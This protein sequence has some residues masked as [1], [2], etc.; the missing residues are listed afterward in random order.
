M[1]GAEGV[2]DGEL[3]QAECLFHLAVVVFNAPAESGEPDQGGQGRVASRPVVKPIKDFPFRYGRVTFSVAAAVREAPC[4]GEPWP[5][6]GE[7]PA[8]D[9]RILAP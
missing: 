9:L 7:E 5:Q 8:L 6:A 4:S 1:Q 3:G 2:G